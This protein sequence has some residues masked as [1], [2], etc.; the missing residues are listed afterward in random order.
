[1]L[2]EKTFYD[3]SLLSYFDSYGS[4]ISVVHMIQSILS[5]QRL[6]E[7]YGHMT[8][9]CCNM[10][11]LE[12][13]DCSQY[14]SI[15]VKEC[16]DDNAK[17]GV[18]Y[19][20]FEC[21]DAMIFA[22]RGSE[23]LDDIHHTTGWQDWMDNFRMFLK[24]PTYQQM[25]TLH[26]IQNS[27]IK[28]PFYLCGHS[29]G[30]NLALFCALTMKEEL[31]EQLAGVC[32]FNAPGITKSILSVYQNRAQDSEFLKKIAIFENENDTIS[33][34]F[35]HL[36]E[37]YY[38]RSC[39]PCTNFEQLYHNHNLYAM[40]FENNLYVLAEK[41]TGIPKLVYHFVNDFFVNLK[42]ERLQAIVHGMDDYFM[43][44]LSMQ[45]LYR[46]VIYHISKYTSLF[47]DISYDEVQTISFQDLMERRKTKLL[48]S[49]IKELQPKEALE[50]VANGI[51]SNKAFSKMN[52]IDIRE[53][54]QN[55]IS[56]YEI[57]VKEKAKDIQ[58]FVSENN[59]KIVQ[60]IKAI[61]NREENNS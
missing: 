6:R 60:T 48:T 2:N 41:K 51:S 50:K 54:T 28:K 46:V 55:I 32:T 13:I 59:E 61:R 35:E 18:V 12:N 27:E 36:K 3:L 23:V 7:D 11:V 25:L 56:N 37:P 44:G 39:Y 8:D 47:E 21:E 38:I 4:G 49:K 45:E 22:F 19:Y 30:G 20:V 10:Q 34:F 57:L 16:F 58:T 42:E 33:S 40:D 14:E 9:F 53:V 31:W 17:S 1:M 52:D 5:D 29:K 26:H 15:Y 43:S 24:N